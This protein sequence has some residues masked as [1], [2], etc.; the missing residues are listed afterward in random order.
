MDTFR[1]TKS[2]AIDNEQA[3]AQLE[4]FIAKEKEAR[5]E[6]SDVTNTTR[7]ST[8]SLLWSCLHYY[9]PKPNSHFLQ[10]T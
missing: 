10:L 7:A 1:I 8:F 4:K 3:V 6:E 9:H 2:K 5:N